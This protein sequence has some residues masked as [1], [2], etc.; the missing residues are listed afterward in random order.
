MIKPE[1]IVGS[2][3]LIPDPAVDWVELDGEAVLYNERLNTVHVLN[4]TATTLWKCLDGSTDLRTLAFDLAEVFSAD[5]E[6]VES[7]VLAAAREFGKQGL[8]QGVEA[9][10]NSVADRAVTSESSSEILDE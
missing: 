6:L 7:D 9:D 2:Y 1:A 10:P 8:L 4:T 3:V 5:R